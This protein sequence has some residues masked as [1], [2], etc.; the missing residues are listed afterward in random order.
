MKHQTLLFLLLVNNFFSF[1][2]L[3]DLAIGQEFENKEEVKNKLQDISLKACFEMA[4]K[5][6]TC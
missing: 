5:K 3:S 2:D 6:S 1:T 4:I